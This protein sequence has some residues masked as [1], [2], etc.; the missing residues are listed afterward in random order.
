MSKTGRPKTPK[1]KLKR[2]FSTKLDP[3]LIDRIGKRAEK[4][5]RSKNNLVE[6]VLDQN[7]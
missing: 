5:Q 3:A 1:N 6:I 7:I 4:E 2:G